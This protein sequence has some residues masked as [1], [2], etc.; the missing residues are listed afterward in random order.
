MTKWHRV[1]RKA[2]CP[3]C[4]KTDWCAFTSDG[5]AR[6]MRVPSD[7][8]CKSGG[9]WLHTTEEKVVLPV[10]KTDQTTLDAERF[11][12][13]LESRQD[14]TCA[15][16]LAE[17]SKQ[18]GGASTGNALW[19]KERKAAAFAM[20]DDTG[21][22]VGIRLRWNNG[23]KGSI[24]GGKSGLLYDASVRSTK[25][26][27]VVEGQTDY[28]IMQHLGYYAIGRQSCIGCEDM[29][30]RL[31]HKIQH[32]HVVIIQDV[33]DPNVIAGTLSM[34][35]RSGAIKLATRIGHAIIRLPHAKDVRAWA[36]RDGFARVKEEIERW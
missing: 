12:R 30:S 13:W 35:G 2:P 18:L 26:I 8:E 10:T 11:W 5:L 23:D 28:L 32:K 24:A 17:L 36:L 19:D 15:V 33:D 21:K 31:C 3:V 4:Q 20:M 9:G 14:D 6:C 25:T 16:G 22:K 1:S 27:F 34:P 7:K 29:V